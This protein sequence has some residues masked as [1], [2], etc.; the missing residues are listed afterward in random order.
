[1]TIRNCMSIA[2]VLKIDLVC[3]VKRYENT[4]KKRLELVCFYQSVWGQAIYYNCKT[5][6]IN[7]KSIKYMLGTW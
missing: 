2:K 4:P 5:K 6:K 1:M 7:P 3:P